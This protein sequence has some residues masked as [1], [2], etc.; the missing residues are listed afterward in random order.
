MYDL[1][2]RGGLVYDGLGNPPKKQDVAVKDGVIRC[3][4]N[5]P[6][7]GAREIDAAGLCVTPG[8]I[9]SHSHADNAVLTHPAMPVVVEQGITTSVT[10]QCGNA[11]FP[12]RSEGPEQDV[13]AFFRRLRAGRTGMNYSLFVGHSSLRYVVMGK[14]MTE[15]TPA[16]MAEMKRLL[17]EALDAGALGLS[18]GLT[19]VPGAY[20]KTAELCELASVLTARGGVLVAHIRNEGDRVEEALDEFLSVVKSAGVTGV[21]SHF[22]ACRACNHGKVKSMIAKVEQTVAEGYPVYMDV[23]PYTATSTSLSTGYVPKEMLSL[24]TEE[25]VAEL[26]KAEVRAE[27]KSRF[28]PTK[29]A[30]LSHVYITSGKGCAAYVGKY[31]NEIA[32]EKGVDMYEACFDVLCDSG[33]TA[34]AC[35][36]TVSEADMQE[37]LSHPRVMVGTDGGAAVNLTMYHPRTRGTFPRAIGK[38]VREVGLLPM[39]EMIRKMTSLPAA[40]YGFAGKGRIAEGFDADLCI[41]DAATIRDRATYAEPHHPPQGLHYVIVGGEIAVEDGKRTETLSGKF[42]P[43]A[44]R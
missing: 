2:I 21:V 43:R 1:V 33:L 9:D 11:I 28:I 25:V 10:G 14:R 23:Y 27:L 42:L 26:K 17:A 44:A 18:L 24:P 35:Y 38:Y 32:A 39:E 22:K 5:V 37:V 34:K 13:P 40:V 8:F 12:N 31:M 41:F 6:E 16:E 29:G 19:Y 36:F 20:A 4:G 3:V 30:D 15:P 7:R